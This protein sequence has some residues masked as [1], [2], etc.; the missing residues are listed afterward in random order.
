MNYELVCHCGRSEAKTRNPLQIKPVIAGLTRN[1]LIICILLL[2]TSSSCRF[3]KQ[4][5]PDEFLQIVQTGEINVL[6]ISGSMSYF[7]YK[8]EP[9]GY[10]YELISSFAENLNLKL[11]IILAENETKLEEMLLSGEGDLIAYNIPVTDEGEKQLKYC[12]REVINEQVLV[13]RSNRGDTILKDINGLIGKDVWVIHDSKYYRQILNLNEELGGGINIRIIEKDTV[14]V[15]DLIE[16]VSK[17]IIPYTI[18]DDDMAKLNKTYHSNINISLLISSPQSSSWAVRK[19]NP[20][21]AA[22]IDEWFEENEN[23]PKY[24]RI[25]KRY[26][27]MSKLPGDEPA[28]IISDKQISTFDR[29]FKKYAAQIKWDWRLLASVSFQESKFYTD[30]VSWAGAAGLMGLM[31]KTAERFGLTIENLYNPE[32]NIKAATAFIKRLNQMFSSVENEEE[33]IKFILA[34]YN[35]GPGHINDAQALA[36]KYEKNPAEWADVNE[37]LKL[38][39]LPKYYNDPVC[40]SGYFSGKGTDNYVRSIIE[41][42]RYYQGRVK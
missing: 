1:P 24:K 29:F 10:E 27:E 23:A 3:N 17:G 12:G 36:E 4:P 30:R 5:P 39:K 21:L 25:I 6:T 7:N 40:K 33:R 11:N 41:R 32:E 19:T 13:Q 34:A 31:P 42:W 15:E 14:T 26:F 35:S 16:M 18:S 37:F 20:G 9:K 2:I 22:A 28:L 8:G 38:K